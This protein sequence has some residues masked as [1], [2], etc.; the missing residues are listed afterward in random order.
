MG[1][2]G[3][4]L[5]LQL[6]SNIKGVEEN[7][8]S[9]IIQTSHLITP[10]FPKL[11]AH[12]VHSMTLENLRHYFDNDARANNSIPVINFNLNDP[13]VVLSSTPDLNLT[14]PFNTPYMNALDQV[15]SHMDDNDFGIRNAPTL[16]KVVH[17]MH[18]L[19]IWELAKPIYKHFQK[20]KTQKAKMLRKLCPCLTDIDNNGI[21]DMMN[22]L[23]HEIRD[24]TSN[25]KRYVFHISWLAPQQNNNIKSLGQIVPGSTNPT[26]NLTSEAEWE[27]WKSNMDMTEIQQTA[28]KQLGLF[29]YCALNF[30]TN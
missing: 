21:M 25:Q 10:E 18:M 28:S 26:T 8:C 16:E 13:T 19:E 6:I 9:S 4:L 12:G 14:N 1:T 17:A 20:K 22:E 7:N 27:I 11:V 2:L 24:I 5:L 30:P 29:V 3:G 15:L 23:A